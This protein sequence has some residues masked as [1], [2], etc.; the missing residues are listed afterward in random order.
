MA[1]DEKKPS[2][3]SPDFTGLWSVSRLGQENK[4]WSKP[5]GAL[6][7]SAFI[8]SWI[9][10]MFTPFILVFLIYQQ[11]FTTSTILFSLIMLPYFLPIAPQPWICRF[12]MKYGAHYFD[13]G[14]SMCFENKPN[15]PHT[16][17][18]APIITAIHPHGILCVG[19]WLAGA[20]RFRATQDIIDKQ[21]RNEY[22][23]EAAF[24]FFR[25]KPPYIAFVADALIQTPVINLLGI[26]LTGC[27][28]AASKQSMKTVMKAG[29]S[30]GILPGGFNEATIFRKGE[31]VI[32][33]RNRKGFVKYC[34]QYGYRIFPAYVFGE[35]ETYHNL[36][37]SHHDSE[38]VIKIKY[39]FNKYKIPTVFPI[40]PHWYLP[41]LPFA[42]TG[43][44][45]VW[46][47][48]TRCQQIEN[49]T[50]QQIDECHQWFIDEINAVFDRHKWRFGY[51]DS[52]KLKIL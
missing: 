34:L 46:S 18:P 13:G 11:Y 30:C 9:L 1:T 48:N 33:I 40:G 27:M 29:T 16:K 28:R 43:L 7:L 22:V 8:H 3:V 38:W 26:K 45:I 37:Y 31:N 4:W 23:H 5:L 42:D 19:V 35:C 21:R 32:Y 6:A 49:P 2:L 47:A 51:D 39:W 14:S 10:G 12:Y 50:K 52:V 36:L 15:L 17:Q 25:N 24:E 41:F 44:H 20:V